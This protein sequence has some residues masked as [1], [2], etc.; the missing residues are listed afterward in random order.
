[1]AG[2]RRSGTG[3]PLLL[4]LFAGVAHA[5]APPTNPQAA[6]DLEAAAD[7][8][9]A[10]SRGDYGRL[11]RPVTDPLGMIQRA[12]DKA[13][14]SAGQ[15]RLPFDPDATPKVRVRLGMPTTIVLPEGER[16]LRS[17]DRDGL[18][19]G[20]GFV[21][22]TFRSGNKITIEATAVGVD[23]TV[24]VYGASGRTY[25]IYV[26]T[27]D[28]KSKSTPDLLVTFS[29]PPVTPLVNE[30]MEKAGVPNLDN[31]A[32][33][34]RLDFGFEMSGDPSLAPDVVFSDGIWTYL[35]W[36]ADRW[37]ST[38]LPAVYRVVDKV[39]E[40]VPPPEVVDSTLVVKE[41]GALSLRSGS[42]YVCIRPTGRKPSD[43]P[44]YARPL[45]AGP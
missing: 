27:E 8:V 28:Y 22:E 29:G 1:M 45:V 7:A 3:L 11:E 44:A 6:L 43:R 17:K 23:T 41:T 4:W 35:K 36:G 12:W 33:A 31:P 24:T 14:P 37:R 42:R 20:S 16:I 39:D 30:N 32:V 13:P 9:G 10:Q 34:A 15:Y 19:F 38:D 5:A 26:R 25:V 21:K 2:F 18:I 40:P